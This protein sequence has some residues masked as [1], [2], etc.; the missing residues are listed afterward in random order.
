MALAYKPVSEQEAN[1]QNTSAPIPEGEYQFKV[2]GCGEQTSKSGNPMLVVKFAVKMP[3]GLGTQ[4]ILRNHTE[5]LLL[6]EQWQWKLRH[7]ADAC[8]LLA[9][10]EANTLDALDLIGRTGRFHLTHQT[11]QDTGQVNARVKVYHKRSTQPVAA[12][13]AVKQ[14]QEVHAEFNDDVPF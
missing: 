11:N 3:N 10:Y 2:T 5:W 8:G 14:N 4:G 13:P 9:K 12:E 6:T 1:N 7:L